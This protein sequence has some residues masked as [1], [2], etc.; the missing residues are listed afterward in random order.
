MT[1]RTNPRGTERI[2]KNAIR[3]NPAV[4]DSRSMRNAGHDN[5]CER[6]NHRQKRKIQLV[7]QRGESWRTDCGAIQGT[8]RGTQGA[9]GE[10]AGDMGLLASRIRTRLSLLA[11]LREQRL[12]DGVANGSL[13]A[14]AGRLTS[15]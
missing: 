14:W 11:T 5:G 4:R 12:T 10:R 3:N 8:R 15:A 2:E 13:D 6:A 9:F 7:F 1:Y